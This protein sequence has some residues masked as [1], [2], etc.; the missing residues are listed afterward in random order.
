[1]G[2]YVGYNQPYILI[3]Q[4][5]GA[6]EEPE[7]FVLGIAQSSGGFL[8]ICHNGSCAGNAKYV[9]PTKPIR[10][11]LRTGYRQVVV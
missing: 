8:I 9:D 5:R 11:I 2:I 1:M 10:P 6:H 3:H 7:K 4:N